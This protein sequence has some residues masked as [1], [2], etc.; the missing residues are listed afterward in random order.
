MALMTSRDQQ[1]QKDML[2]RVLAFMAGTDLDRSPPEIMQGIGE[3]V[4]SITGVEDPYREI[5][6]LH[7]A[8]ALALLPEMDRIVNGSP[9]P[10]LTGMK[11]AAAGNIIDLGARGSVSEDEILR[12]LDEALD[13]PLMGTDPSLL[14]ERTEKA[15][16][17]LYLADNAGETVFDRKFLQQL[18][19]GRTTVAVRGGPALND[20]TMKDAVQA[21][22]DSVASLIDNG[23]RA[24]A[25]VLDDC[26]REFQRLFRSADLVLAKGQGNYESLSSCG[27][28]VHFLFRVKCRL[29]AHH[30]GFPEGSL[31]LLCRG[32]GE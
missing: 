31:V 19:P 12:T 8:A 6:E 2:R 16:T 30:C 11:L 22:L 13:L 7:T 26:S 27:R 5:K 1:A 14:R 17:I 18:P 29:V 10:F 3:V 28:D 15:G 9:D 4:R 20:A 24:P 32:G 23:S 21:G 25:T